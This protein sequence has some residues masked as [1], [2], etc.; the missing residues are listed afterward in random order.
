MRRMMMGL[1][2]CVP[3]PAAQ[4]RT[5]P[6]TPGEQYQ[7]LLKQYDGPTRQYVNNPKAKAVSERFLKLAREHPDDPAAVDALGWVVTHTLFTPEAGAAMSLLARD[8]IGS[9]KLGP[10]IR[11]IDTLYGGPFEP[12]ATMLRAVAQSSPHRGVR[13]RA[14]LALGHDQVSIK[15]TAER[16]LVQHS[17]F[18]KGAKVPFVDEPKLTAADLD[19]MAD[20][21]AAH[22][23]KVAREYG[24]IDD[25][26]AAA[27][28]DLR[29]LRSL[30]VGMG[31]PEIEGEDID[32]KRFRLSDYRGKVVVLDFWNHRGCGV[33][34]GMYPHL[35]SLAR[36]LE[37]RPFALLGIDS[38]DDRDELKKL[39]DQGQVTWRFWCDGAFDN[40]PIARRWNISFWPTTFVLDHK[41]VIRHKNILDEKALNDAVDGLLKEMDAADHDLNRRRED[42]CR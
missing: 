8:Q 16:D 10:I 23:A 29:A 31:A 6:Q 13:G 36:R 24:D 40:G 18:L 15:E 42:K 22:F 26:G 12:M 25:L 9:E 33:C 7:A 32:G 39:G 30:S 38:D 14:C 27:E 5:E 2:L 21:A 28:A 1:L 41:G 20:E 3:S 35:R 19:A 37:G 4:D 17:L 34:R 11:E